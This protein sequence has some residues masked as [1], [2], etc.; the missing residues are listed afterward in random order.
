MTKIYKDPKS[1]FDEHKKSVITIGNF[2]GMH[3]GHQTIFKTAKDKAKQLGTKFGVIT[4]EPHPKLL[5]KPDTPPFRITPEKS[6]IRRMKKSG[7]DF[8]IIFSF[9]H[10]F[11]NMKA[12]KFISEIIIE[13]TKSSHIVVGNDFHFGHKRTGNIETLKQAGINVTSLKKISD[14]DDEIYSSTRVREEIRKGNIRNADEILGWEWEIEGK[15]IHGNKDGRKLGYPTAN[16]ELGESLHPSYGVYAALTKIDGENEW[17]HA[18]INIGIS[19]MFKKKT[20]LVESYI[21]DFNKEIYGKNIRIKPIKKIR[22]EQKFN[23][24]EELIKQ[25]EKDCLKIK[26]ILH[27]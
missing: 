9:N 12:D 14:E 25:I 20:A 10:D 5:F 18:A 11:A 23:N 19:P 26:Q 17:R 1:I 21:F 4:F 13:L 6:K 27:N 15:V 7:A 22:D 3:I 8:I 24:I 16:V 2:D